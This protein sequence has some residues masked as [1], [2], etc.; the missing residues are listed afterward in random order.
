MRANHRT[1]R[2]VDGGAPKRA[3]PGGHLVEHRA[4]AEDVAAGIDR[5]ARRLLGRHIGG[6][7]GDRPRRAECAVRGDGG[8]V[9]V[10]VLVGSNQFG[11]A[12]IEHLHRAVGP[13]HHIGRFEIAMDD[14]ARMRG[15]ERV[16]DGD[17]D[18]ERFAEAHALPWDQRIDALAGHVLHHDE[19]VILGGVDLV[20]RDDVR[21]IE[22]RC[23]LRFLDEA[24]AAALI[25]DAIGGQ[26]LDR[27]VAPQP[28]VPRAIDLAH[29]PGTDQTEN[30]VAAEPC[31]GL[32]G[33]E[34]G[35]II[36]ARWQGPRS[37]ELAGSR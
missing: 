31:T 1:E 17:G 10:R 13:D 24:A 35:Q 12:E 5:S 7:A 18:A 19:I 22:R 34:R 8:G 6:R 26:H 21:M 36:R 15:R 16:G 14:A 27:D 23:R 11:Q 32:Q 33:H 37:A 29:A 3:Y 2:F 30:V 20:N 4:E 9:R 28:W 25:R